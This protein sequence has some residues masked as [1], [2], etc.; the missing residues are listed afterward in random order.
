MGHLGFGITQS[1]EYMEVYQKFMKKYD[2]GG[3]IEEIT[4]EILNEYG[5]ACA[6]NDDYSMHGV[7]FALAR[8]QWMCGA[9]SPDMYQKV[10]EIVISGQ[11]MLEFEK[12]NGEKKALESRKKSLEKFLHALEKPRST[13]RKRR[14][15]AK[16][17]ELPSVA[18]GDVLAYRWK[19]KDRILVVLDY[20]EFGKW[21]PMLFGCLLSKE[22]P[23]IPDMES[24]LEE[25]VSFWGIYDANSFLP[26]SQVRIIGNL[27]VPP[28]RYK[29][30]FGNTL[31][32]G[33]RSDF[34]R[35]VQP[36]RPTL[37]LQELLF[38]KNYQEIR[39]ITH[40]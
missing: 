34:S 38:S 39:K 13:V 17:R 22:Y 37:T 27:K 15:P 8:A 25:P 12:A 20:V 30:L 7:Y 1:E 19:G 32:Y 24:L 2:A 28:Q 4:R 23:E 40:T 9:L 33:E 35:E 29:A 5:K 10:W 16:Q 26:K 31:V 21:K 14:P 18:V 11:N 36:E 3:P 6:K